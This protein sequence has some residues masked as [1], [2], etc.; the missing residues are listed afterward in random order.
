MCGGPGRKL[1]SPQ[2]C[3]LSGS[4]LYTLTGHTVWDSCIH[5]PKNTHT[6]IHKH[7]LYSQYAHMQFPLQLRI[8]VGRC[9]RR[10]P[11]YKL[12]VMNTFLWTSPTPPMQTDS[13]TTFHPPTRC[14]RVPQGQGQ[15]G[16]P[17]V[18]RRKV[19]VGSQGQDVLGGSSCY[20]MDHTHTLSALYKEEHKDMTTLILEWLAQRD[21]GCWFSVILVFV[22]VSVF[23]Y[24][25]I[26]LWKH[27]SAT[28][29]KLMIGFTD[30]LS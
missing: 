2:P 27:I 10:S 30:F 26:F 13:T 15:G 19:T 23:I 28:K 1:P 7:I 17:H 6:V 3:Y 8:L 4:S 25:V 20:H 11:H 24:Y 9:V 16:V 29:R 21:R 12:T 5:K 14:G 18:C 22:V